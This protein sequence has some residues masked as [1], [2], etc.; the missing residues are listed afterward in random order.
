MTDNIF[1]GPTTVPEED[2]PDFV[3]DEAPA[4]APAAEEST[5]EERPRD[6]ET[7]RFIKV[8]E[9]TTE[10]TEEVSEEPEAEV[11]QPIV[12]QETPVEE[13]PDDGL[14]EEAVKVWAGK[15]KSAEELE[16]GYREIRS[17][18]Q[19][20]AEQRNAYQQAAQEA[21]Y[22]A[23]QM[24]QALRNAMPIV[25]QAID[26]QRQ[27]PQYDE[28]GNQLPPQEPQERPL[29][30]AD[31]DAQVQARLNQQFQQWQSQARLQQEQANLY[32]AGKAAMDAFFERH[33]EVEKY[34]DTDTDIAATILAFNQAWPDSDVDITSTDALEIAYEASQRPALRTVLQMNAQYFDSDEGMILARKLASEID[35]VTQNATPRGT[36]PRSNTPVVEKGSSATPPAGKPK[37]EF[38]EAAAAYREENKRRGDSVFFGG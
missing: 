27:V 23:Q 24:E 3:L 2:L 13:E 28:Y 30:Q 6:P 18:Q 26:M 22:R 25:Q 31:V 16:K 32:N 35:G 5:S 33:P 8:E 38:D 9:E 7:G 17:L 11:E 14:T 34:S 21:Q 19:R 4:E 1:D 37:D 20:T 29:T 36:K 15:Y 10:A 12:D